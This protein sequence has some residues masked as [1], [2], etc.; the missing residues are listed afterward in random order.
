MNSKL[1]CEHFEIP[2][3][4]CCEYCNAY[5]VC[6]LKAPNDIW[7]FHSEIYEWDWNDLDWP[8]E[9]QDDGVCWR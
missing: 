3:T 4:V 8:D 6:P 1:I 5:P 7:D 2:E 9:N